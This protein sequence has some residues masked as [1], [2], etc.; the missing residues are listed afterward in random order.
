MQLTNKHI[1]QPEY[2]LALGVIRRTIL[3][4]LNGYG[5]E[6]LAQL[7]YPLPQTA[8]S[9]LLDTDPEQALA[10]TMR[11]CQRL[12]GMDDAT[13]ANV[14]HALAWGSQSKLKYLLQGDCTND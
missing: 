6:T 4:A 5:G 13:R 8:I 7:F 2:A 9:I 10:T 3:D 14:W 12:L 1:D 11:A